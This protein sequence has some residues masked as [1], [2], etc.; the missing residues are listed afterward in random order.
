[1]G[2]VAVIV[3]AMALGPVAWA[4]QP[5]PA[6][7]PGEPAAVEPTSIFVVEA[8]GTDPRLLDAL[9]TARVRLAGQGVVLEAVTPRPDETAAGRA[10]ALVAGGLARGVFWLDERTPGEIRV[11]LLDA[12][13]FAWVRRVPVEPEA[14]E[15]SREAVWL[16]VEASGRALAVGEAVAMEQAP[17]EAIAEPDEPGEP[18]VVEPPVAS[19]LAPVPTPTPAAA[20]R[21]R[22]WLGLAYLGDGLARA[23]P[24]QSGAALDGALDLGA[25]W[26]LS[27][28]YG[29]LVPWQRGDPVVTWRHRGELR[30]GLRGMV[31]ARLQPHGL[32]GGAVEAVRWRTAEGARGGLRVV[33]VATLD[34][35]L[36]VRLVADLWL[37]LEAGAGVVVNRFDFVRCA[38]GATRC[39]GMLRQVALAPWRVRPRARAGVAVRF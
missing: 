21:P 1:M 11:F 17:P 38:A 7:A 10:R 33:G 19:S 32:L 23:V 18:A 29:A 25:R 30:A 12:R 31:G 16:I 13:G 5:A 22:P 35:G 24:W 8:P 20:R 3:A 9:A 2:A 15:A 6:P 37:V 14:I 34:A 28:G 4:A 36:G 27:L 39:D 26:R